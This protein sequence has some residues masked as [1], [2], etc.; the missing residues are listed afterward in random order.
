L[1]PQHEKSTALLRTCLNVTTT[2]A[3]GLIQVAI[4]LPVPGSYR[5]SSVRPS[6]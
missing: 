6:L 4:V 5:R 3:G 2:K 1:K